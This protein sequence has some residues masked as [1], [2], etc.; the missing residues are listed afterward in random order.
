MKTIDPASIY[1]FLNAEGAARQI[2][3]GD[4][5][6]SQTECEFAALNRGWL[7]S[8]FRFDADWVNWE[9]HPEGDEIVYLLEG[10]VTLVLDLAEGHTSHRLDAPGAVVV[11]KGVWHTARTTTACRMLHIT[12]GEG[13]QSRSAAD[14]PH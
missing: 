6:W 4:A 11:P 9:M 12:R 14:N 2:P 10:R 13:T 5:F 7:V 8:E 1:V 3:G